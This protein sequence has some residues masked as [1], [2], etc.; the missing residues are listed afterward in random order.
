MKLRLALMLIS[1]ALLAI[2]ALYTAVALRLGVETLQQEWFEGEALKFSLIFVA[3]SLLSSYLME[4]YSLPKRSKRE[5]FIDCLQCGCAGFFFLAVAYYLEPNLMLGKGVLFLSIALLCLYQFIWHVVSTPGKFQPRFSRRVLIL[6]SG[7]LARE[8]GE[9]VAAD[10]LFTLAG[11]L[12][13]GATDKNVQGEELAL[14]PASVPRPMIQMQGDLLS[15]V[16]KEEADLVVVALSERRGVLPLQEMMQCQLNGIEI[17]DAPTFYEILQGKLML[18]HI[19]PGW[20]ILS[21]GLRSTALVN[22]FKRCIDIVFSLAG[23]VLA[24]PFFPLVALAIKLD[25]AGPLFFKQVCVGSGEK[26]FLL[27]KFRS[28]TGTEVSDN[29]GWAVENES[30]LTRVGRL[31]RISHIDG[32]PQL[33]N[34]LKSDMSLIGPRPE[35]P[36][37]VLRLNKDIYHYSKRHTIKPGLTGWAQVRHPS[38]ATLEDMVEK[39]RYDLYYIKNLSLSLDSLIMFETVKFALFGRDMR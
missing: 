35:P 17:F 11:Y 36:E 13:C 15:T 10:S 3:S 6:G 7:K 9:L 38:G 21:A 16:R 25:S 2:A 29:A 4:V 14:W 31:L 37:F 19:S 32:I 26:P 24:A 33:Y 23:L 39:L 27:Y 18:E 34:V 30:L 5:I 22:V 20:M 8:L 12:D 1:D 28:T